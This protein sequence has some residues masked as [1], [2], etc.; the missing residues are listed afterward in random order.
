ML[1]KNHLFAII[2]LFAALFL[3]VG[4]ESGTQEVADAP[5]LFGLPTLTPS[6]TY[7]PSVTYTPSNTSTATRTP[8]NTPTRTATATSTPSLTFTPRASETASLTPTNTATNT[9]VATSTFTATATSNVPV[10]LSFTANVGSAAPGA[11]ITLTWQTE[12]DSARIEQLNAQGT[13]VQVIGTVTPNGSLPVTVPSG[14][15]ELVNY[16]LVAMRAG[17][18]TSRTVPISVTCPIAWFFGTKPN[19]PPSGCPSAL[20]A[21]GG[22]A[23]QRMQNGFL[24]YINANSQNRIYALQVFSG[25]QAYN[26]YPNAT[27]N[28]PTGWDGSTT[29]NCQTPPSGTIAPGYAPGL[30]SFD[31]LYCA[32]SQ[33]PPILAGDWFAS[34]GWGTTGFDPNQRT[35]QTSDT[36]IIFIDS[37]YGVLRLAPSS[38]GSANGTWT[39]PY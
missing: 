30:A 15:G 6:N 27:G 25:T 35:I 23:A 28:P 18:E 12:S 1:P 37:P 7:T 14:Q 29:Y 38:S 34:V 4:C 11:Q 26:S 5:T 3:L 24:I 39:G 22:G 13:L 33:N 19:L 16:R 36:G 8:T 20:G 21:I 2:T 9:P 17:Q 10:I 31:W 32:S